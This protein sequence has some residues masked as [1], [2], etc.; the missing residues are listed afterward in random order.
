MKVMLHETM[1]K[2]NPIL[3]LAVNLF[4]ENIGRNSRMRVATTSLAIGSISP[5][6]K[7]R[8]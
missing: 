8:V 7:Y 1:L 2:L 3:T 6:F 5:Y 4:F